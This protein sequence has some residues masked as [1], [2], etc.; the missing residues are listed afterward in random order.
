MRLLLS[1][2]QDLHI[3]LERMRL[4]WGE[5]DATQA[6]R[7]SVRGATIMGVSEDG[8]PAFS[9]TADDVPE[10]VSDLQAADVTELVAE[11]I[12]RS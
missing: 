3:P 12:R 7:A 6:M 1:T 2:A 8:V 5:T 4:N 9:H 10:N 11:L